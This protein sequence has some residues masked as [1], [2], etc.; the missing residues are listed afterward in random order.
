MGRLEA[1]LHD[2]RWREAR[3][4][5]ELDKGGGFLDTRHLLYENGM[6]M[7][8]MTLV[9]S[10]GTSKNHENYDRK[11]TDGG[12]RQQPHMCYR[13]GNYICIP[14]LSVVC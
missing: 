1:H 7:I 6:T 4:G 2:D 13:V 8:K 10:A 11:L 9:S 3:T 5:E 14:K 12:G